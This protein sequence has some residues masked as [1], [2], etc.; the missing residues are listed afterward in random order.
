L[1]I[2]TGTCGGAYG[3]DAF[4]VVRLDGVIFGSQ[5]YSRYSYAWNWS[6]A[7]GI[8]ITAGSHTLTIENYG[9]AI[10]PSWTMLV[11]DGAVSFQ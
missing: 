9:G 7:G 10:S 4:V 11:V 2:L 5:Q 3:E 6:F 8:P 1:L